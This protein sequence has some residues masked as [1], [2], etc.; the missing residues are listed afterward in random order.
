MKKA[1]QEITI[2]F[3]FKEKHEPDTQ[4]HLK[5]VAEEWCRSKGATITDAIEI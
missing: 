5:H 1:P 3:R 2:N 4:A